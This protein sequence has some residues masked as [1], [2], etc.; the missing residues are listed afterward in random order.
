MM[1]KKSLFLNLAFYIVLLLSASSVT[2]EGKADDSLKPVTIDNPGVSVEQLELML[3]PLTRDELFAE[4][5]V[6]L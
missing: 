2:A 6:W 1:L 5:D 3:N 4:A